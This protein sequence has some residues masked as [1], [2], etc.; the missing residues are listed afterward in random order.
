MAA[1]GPNSTQRGE[2][3]RGRPPLEQVNLVSKYE[4]ARLISARVASLANNATP[5]VDERPE[6]SPFGL[7]RLAEKEFA[8]RSLPLILVRRSSSGANDACPVESLVAP[9]NKMELT[10]LRMQ[11]T[12]GCPPCSSSA[13]PA[14][15]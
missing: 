3:P 10:H 14:P 6:D 13:P 2:Q 15:Q 7:M 5:S 8:E 1:A 12:S 9:A 11:T 4:Y